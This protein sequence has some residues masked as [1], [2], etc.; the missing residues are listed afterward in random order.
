[1]TS[2]Y[3]KTIVRYFFVM[4]NFPK[5]GLV[6]ILRILGKIY[7]FKYKVLRDY[8]EIIKI[9]KDLRNYGKSVGHAVQS[10]KVT[11]SFLGFN[12]LSLVIKK[13]EELTAEHFFLNRPVNDLKLLLKICKEY[14]DIL[15]G[16]LIFD[17]GCGT[18][19]HL[20]YLAD[21]YKCQGIGADVYEPA[22]NIANKANF[23][24]CV[25]FHMLSM[26]ESQAVNQ[27]IPNKCDYVFVNSWLNHV[28]QYPG[29][30]AM[31]RELI[32]SCRFML[33]I[34]SVKFHL[35]TLIPDAELLILEVRDNT[36]YALI[37]G[38]L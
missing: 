8:N 14:I 33:I 12:L 20:F 38:E 5:S 23:D 24:N 2:Y 31:I 17:P 35:E 9:K 37:K 25:S 4:K 19:K 26:T 30:N 11:F 16:D 15:E 28:Y 6:F 27:L 29:Y 13:G 7:G 21:Y 1:M 36:Q 10:K 34:N 32:K 22:I 18:G 3:I